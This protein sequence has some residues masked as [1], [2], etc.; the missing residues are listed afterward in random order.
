MAKQAT[1]Q[2]TDLSIMAKK[3]LNS[4][5]QQQLKSRFTKECFNYGKKRHYIKDCCKATK[6]KC[7]D[8]KATQKA[9]QTRLNNY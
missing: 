1:S 5:S 6:K 2:N 7:E 9:K 3:M 8:K 4:Q